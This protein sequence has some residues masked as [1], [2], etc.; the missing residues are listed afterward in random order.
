MAGHESPDVKRFSRLEDALASLDQEQPAGEPRALVESRL[1]ALED[2]LRELPAD[3]TRERVSLELEAIAALVELDRLADASER[4]RAAVDAAIGVD[5]FAR[6]AEAC[7]FIYMLGGDDAV[8]ALGQG[9]WLAVTY[10]V[11]PELT[12]ALLQHVVDETPDDSDGAAVAAAA[13][14]YVVDL[15]APPERREELAL[16]SGGLLAT[17]ARRHAGVQ[18]REE[19]DAWVERLELD[20]PARFLVRLRNVV[21]VMVQ[22]AWWFDRDGLRA[23]LPVN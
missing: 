15:R 22:D 7:R 21:D 2:R 10:P 23:R 8:V 6:A 19:F 16:F 12:L 11:D 18:T 4:A 13:A 9:V 17:V 14:Q 3:A 1:Q 20:D 5:A